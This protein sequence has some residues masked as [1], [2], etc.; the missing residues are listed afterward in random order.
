MQKILFIFSN[1]SSWLQALK[2]ILPREDWWVLVFLTWISPRLRTLLGAPII[3]SRLPILASWLVK[4]CDDYTLDPS[5]KKEKGGKSRFRW[6]EKLKLNK[7]E[8]FHLYYKRIQRMIWVVEKSKTLFVDCRGRTESKT[9]RRL[10]FDPS[11]RRRREKSNGFSSSV[12]STHPQRFSVVHKGW[13]FVILNEN[14]MLRWINKR[15]T[16]TILIHLGGPE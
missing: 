3:L 8:I 7:N 15:L 12:T 2:S 4:R 11:I 10:L 13:T 1:A 6:Q 16:K 14:Q 5:N 9:M